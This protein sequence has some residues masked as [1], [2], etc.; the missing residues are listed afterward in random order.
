MTATNGAAKAEREESRRALRLLVDSAAPVERKVA[1][2]R[3]SLLEHAEDFEQRADEAQAERAEILRVANL[4]LATAQQRGVVTLLVAEALERVE[5]KQDRVLDEL[6][7]WKLRAHRAL[8]AAHRAEDAAA[9]A[10]TLDPAD[11]ERIADALSKRVE[12]PIVKAGKQG[13]ARGIGGTLA[14]GSLLIA[15]GFARDPEA[16]VGAVDSLLKIFGGG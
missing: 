10:Q 6:E 1:A 16:F 5:G 14:A 3:D 12:K 11:V 7:T 8:T 13:L 9:R 15:G 4:G 2:L